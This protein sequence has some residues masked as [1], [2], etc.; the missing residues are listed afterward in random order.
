MNPSIHC[1]VLAAS[2]LLFANDA[3]AQDFLQSGEAYVTRFSGTVTQGGQ[4]TI[5]TTG[6]VGSLVDIRQPG[7]AAQGQHWTNEPQRLSVTAGQVGQVFGIAFDDANPAN[8]YLT[9]TSAFGLHRTSDK[10]NWMSGMWPPTGGPGT[11]WKLNASNNYKPEMFA[12]ITFGGRANTGAA[13]G[14]IAYDRWNKQHFVSDLET[15]MIHRLSVSDGSELGVYDHG[16]AGRA[17]FTDAATSTQN[18]LVKVAFDANTKARIKNCPGGDFAK[19]PECWNLAD[20]RRRVWGLGVRR[21]A[22]TGMVRLYYAVWSSQGLGNAAFAGA[23]DQEKRNSL[24]SVATA[25]DGSF[26]TTDIRREFF[27]PDFFT[28]ATDI[29]RAGQSRPISDIAFPKTGDQTVMLVA[30]RGGLRNLGLGARASFARPHEARIL[31]YEVDANGIWN[32]VGRYDVGFY[33]RSKHGQPFLRANGAGG[34]DFGFGYDQ[35]WAMDTAQEGEFV[36]ATGDALCD[37]DGPCYDLTTDKRDETSEVHG[38]QGVPEDAY[39]EVVPNAA[40]KPYPVTGT[41]YPATGPNKAYMIDIDRNID[42]SDKAIAAELARNDATRIG[43]VEVYGPVSAVVVAAPPAVTP[44]YPGLLPGVAPSGAAPP[45]YPP[46]ATP[47]SPPPGGAAPKL[48]IVKTGPAQCTAPGT[49]TYDIIVK[50]VGSVAYTGPIDVKDILPNGWDLAGI[51]AGAN[52]TCTL[53]PQLGG[54]GQ[55]DCRYPATNLLPGQSVAMKLA[56][57]IPATAKPGEVQN[58]ADLSYTS[59]LDRSCVKTKL[60]GGKPAF[61]LDFELLKTGKPGQVECKNNDTCTF[62]LTL[63]NKGAKT[64]PDSPSFKL[65]IKDA[66]PS[67]WTMAGYGPGSKWKC[68]GTGAALTCEYLGPPMPTGASE[69]LAI[70]ANVPA[71]ETRTQVKNCADFKIYKQPGWIGGGLFDDNKPTNNKP[72]YTVKLKHVQ[73]GPE[74]LPPGS[75]VLL[76]P[77]LA[78]QKSGPAQCKRNAAC[79]FA[80]KMTNV[81]TDTY[82]GPITVEDKIFQ[83]PGIKLA[84]WTAPWACKQSALGRYRCH[85]PAT[86]L[87]PNSSISLTLDITFP[88]GLPKLLSAV[89]NC[90]M[91]SATSTTKATP[92]ACYKVPV[93]KLPLPDLAITKAAVGGECKHHS[94]SFKI[95]VTNK[96]KEP[97][98]GPIYIYDYLEKRPTKISSYDP[99]QEWSCEQTGFTPDG[100][101]MFCVHTPVTLNQNESV[102]ITLNVEYPFS[103]YR[104]VKNCTGIR[105]PV[106]DLTN[107]DAVFDSVM[108]ALRLLGYYKGDKDGS[109]PSVGPNPDLSKAIN[110][111]LKTQGNLTGDG[112]ITPQLL[113]LLFPDSAAE[114]GDDYKGNDGPVCISA[115]TPEEVVITGKTSWKRFKIDLGLEFDSTGRRDCWPP[116]CSFFEFIATNL[117][118]P[119][120]VGPISMRITLPP[121]TDFPKL[122]VTKSGTACPATGWSCERTDDGYRCRHSACSLAVDEQVAI[123][124]DGTLLPGASEPPQTEMSKTACAVLE[125]EVPPYKGI[126]IEQLG[127]TK[128]TASTCFTTRILAAVSAPPEGVKPLPKLYD[129][130]F[131]KIGNPECT[132][133][134]TCGF[135]FTF[136]NKGPATFWDQIVFTDELPSGWK[137][138]PPGFMPCTQS[139][140]RVTCT[141]PHH[142]LEQNWSEESILNARVPESETRTD[143]TNCAWYDLDTAAGDYNPSNN[144]DCWDIKIRPKLAVTPQPPCAEGQQWDPIERICTPVPTLLEPKPEKADLAVQKSGPEECV[145]DGVCLYKLTVINRGPGIYEAPLT[146]IDERPK[147]WELLGGFPSPPWECSKAGPAIEC[148]GGVALAPGASFKLDLELKAPGWANARAREVENCARI[149]RSRSAKDRHRVSAMEVQHILNEFGYQAGPADGILG[150]RTRAAIRRY[151]KDKGLPQSGIID[152]SLQ[153][154]FFPGGHVVL[155]RDPNADNDRACVLTAIAGPPEA[156]PAEPPARARPTEAEPPEPPALMAPPGEPDKCPAGQFR[157]RAGQCVCPE[158]QRWDGRRCVP[159]A[160]ACPPG[161]FRKVGQCV[162]PEGQRWDGRRCVPRA[163]QCPPGQSRRGGRCV[164]DEGYRWDGARCVEREG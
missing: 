75:G 35:Y 163:V 94:C 58:C 147:G 124:V 93:P 56:L 20:F 36:W 91:V 54:G 135:A 18:S 73:F 86:T 123:R 23:A 47:P 85:H 134:G 11:V 79:K 158:G 141:H 59:G 128:Q 151:Q 143:V 82:S 104:Q 92:W 142:R 136:L 105:W 15:G 48:T 102:S 31:R 138:I 95:T 68:Q 39:G 109:I 50:N 139:G 10:T 96:N 101:A 64:F 63:T 42:S 90:A 1:A 70:T 38:L 144:K 61:S 106:S 12:N 66:L 132:P 33:D 76:V 29:A 34:I 103:G 107:K 28:E 62:R 153:E 32:P 89:E 115:L 149:E 78:I 51:G 41:P 57:K 83:Y 55:V 77:D 131:Q 19:T 108:I 129:L 130:E 22:T 126:D 44:A 117:V 17:R 8:I 45:P 21:D 110:D 81:G 5:D 88:A 121:D 3:S 133:G 152:D 72:C 60:A 49:C 161:Q 6:T 40:L 127:P 164:C 26:D 14:N 4:T 154:A 122:R 25:E 157:N 30:E 155:P 148:L 52:W 162:C 112:K 160:A 65:W 80:L 16:I 84:A 27:L 43:D 113:D 7:E 37:P 24:W 146:I 69:T 120:Y 137:M 116:N 99:K 74:Q 119:Y 87:A 140:D 9:A 2:F 67:G 125:W 71:F 145:P 156:A 114:A 46:G 13:L 53:A 150:P 118:V 97:Y 159:R 111:Y 100:N 98:K